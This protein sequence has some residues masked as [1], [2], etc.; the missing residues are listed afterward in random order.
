VG[1]SPP[2]SNWRSPVLRCRD[3]RRQRHGGRASQRQ[4]QAALDQAP[5]WC[6]TARN[7][8][9]LSARRSN[10]RL[11]PDRAGRRRRRREPRHGERARHRYARV[12][13][14]VVRP[15]DHFTAGEES[16]LANWFASGLSLPV[17]RPTKAGRCASGDALHWCT[18]LNTGHLALIARHGPE[19][20]RD[21][22]YR[23]AGTCLV[24]IAVPCP[25]PGG[26]GRPWYHP[27]GH[28]HAEPA[29]R[30]NASLLVAVRRDMGGP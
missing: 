19:P 27:V 18:T 11:H 17:F 3:R 12:L 24:T 1:R 30:A 20:F 23:G 16:A 14:V 28:R 9:P 4:G 8:W 22:G 29:R 13:E 15:P 2:R 10:R 25:I 21:R 5:T 26:G 6:S 7:T